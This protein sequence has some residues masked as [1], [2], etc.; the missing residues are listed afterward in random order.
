MAIRVGVVD[1][2]DKDGPF[3]AAILLYPVRKAED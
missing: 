3:Q 1:G 2:G